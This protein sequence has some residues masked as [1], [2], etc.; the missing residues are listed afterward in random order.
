[1]VLG[2]QFRPELIATILKL[3]CSNQKQMINYVYW[4]IKQANATI[5]KI[6]STKYFTYS[7]HFD[8]IAFGNIA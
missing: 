8:I 3:D 5:N 4:L 2:G 6:F 1:M 7:K